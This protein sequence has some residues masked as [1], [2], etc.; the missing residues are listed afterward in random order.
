MYENLK[1]EMQKADI[2]IEQ[3]AEDLGVH[4][5]TASNKINGETP[6]AIEE[7]IVIRN[8]RFPHLDFFYLFKKFKQVK[9]HEQTS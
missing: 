6:L 7:A 8:M 2:T 9:Q 3:I 4:R 5:N 1:F